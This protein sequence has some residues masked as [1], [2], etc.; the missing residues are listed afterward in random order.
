MV[1]PLNPLNYEEALDRF[2][3]DSSL[4]EKERVQN[5]IDKFD[6]ANPSANL[7]AKY[8]QAAQNGD[9][10]AQ[11]MMH[12]VKNAPGEPNNPKTHTFLQK[13]SL[14]ADQLH[15]GALHGQLRDKAQEYGINPWKL[16]KPEAMRGLFNTSIPLVRDPKFPYALDQTQGTSSLE[17][18]GRLQARDRAK[19]S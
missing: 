2:G 10:H 14:Y 16:P 11:L 7:R 19:K 8:N 15:G 9:E 5:V 12:L 13:L 6:V 18:L 4:S 3:G 1:Q 17:T